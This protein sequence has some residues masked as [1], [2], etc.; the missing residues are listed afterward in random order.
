MANKLYLWKII[1]AILEKI[2]LNELFLLLGLYSLGFPFS[3]RRK[4]AH[5]FK[6]EQLL[7]YIVDR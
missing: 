4:S 6:S 3:E 5:I 2:K 1:K 7:S